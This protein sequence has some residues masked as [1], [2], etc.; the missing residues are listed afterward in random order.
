VA[1][2]PRWLRRARLSPSLR[3]PRAP[4]TLGQDTEG[5]IFGGFTPAQWESR[6]H[7]CFKADPSLNSV[8][9]TLENPHNFPERKCA[10]N[11]EAKDRAVNCNSS[12][13]PIFFDIWISDNCNTNTDSYSNLGL[14]YA[15]DTCLGGQTVL[16]GS[17]DF[18]VKEI[19]VFE[20][21]E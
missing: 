7:N 5:S 6:E 11:A 12:W 9:F 8:L 14:S 17:R 1:R 18:T 13:G 16:T 21:T 2:Q 15:N 19:E 3:W 4:L 20:I 10:L